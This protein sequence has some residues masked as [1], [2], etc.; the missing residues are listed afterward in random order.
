MSNLR[1]IKRRIKSVQN[2]EQITKAMEMVSAAKLRRAQAR[3]EAARP[4][5]AKMKETL[6]NL[7]AVA[8]EVNHPL[9]EKRPVKRR[10]LVLIT[11]D[12]GLAGS[13]NSNVIR[14]AEAYMKSEEGEKTS[15]ITIGRKAGAYFRR[16]GFDP[17][18]HYQEVGDQVDMTKAQTLSREIVQF[19]VTGE[20]DEI[21]VLGT[22]FISA[23]SR[24]LKLEPF[25]PIEPPA[26]KKEPVGYIFEP[27]AARIFSALLPRY[28]ANRLIMTLLEA[29]ASEHGARMVAMGSA[30]RNATDM[31]ESLT[32]QRN[33]AR[34]A[35]ITKEIAEIVGGAEALK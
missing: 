34:Q 8:R 14:R 3:L 21:Q 26:G 24:A 10:A 30:S 22:R 9:F 33:R 4:Y 6:E 1:D 19:F 31:I 17:I 13:Y 12:K 32:L 23:M 7:A 35:A 16:R 5:G 18:A 28:V 29:S 25:L 2:M 11:A 20:V 27:D 15:L